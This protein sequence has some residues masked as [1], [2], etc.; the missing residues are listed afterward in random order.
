MLIPVL[1]WPLSTPLLAL[2]VLLSALIIRLR[3]VADDKGVTV[4]N[5]LGS[6]T[7]GWDDIDG[8]RFHRGSWG[9]AKLKSGAELR[10]PAV[11]FATLP[12]L[13]AVSSGRVPNPYR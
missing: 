9:R 11:T 3:T 1:A 2:P 8:L 10:L 5:L 4:R 12:Q 7:A 6:Q 13:T